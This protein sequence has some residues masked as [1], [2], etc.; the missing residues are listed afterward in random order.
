[1]AARFEA[2][3]GVL[4]TAE[5]KFV[6]VGGWP[7]A[8]LGSARSTL[9]VDMVYARDRENVRRL[10]A[11]LE[12]HAP[13]LRG[14]PPGLPFVFDEKTI[15]NGMNFTR[16]SRALGDFDLLGE[17]AGGGTYEQLVPYTIEISAFGHRCRCVTLECLIQLKRAAGR[18]KNLETIAELQA[19]LEEHKAAGFEGVAAIREPR[20]RAAHFVT[21]HQNPEASRARSQFGAHP[22][23]TTATVA[24]AIPAHGPAPTWTG[25]S[26]ACDS[27]T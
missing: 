24:K 15:R 17:V 1:M 18:P 19:I 4:C 14:A 6:I 22:K 16:T 26:G 20:P 25:A 23:T 10:A 13:Y 21:C 8:L 27:P 5:I 11:A 9:D 2:V 3:A 7:A 12:P